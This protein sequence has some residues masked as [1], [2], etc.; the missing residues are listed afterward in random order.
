MVVFLILLHKID[1]STSSASGSV[2]WLAA[3]IINLAFTSGALSL[4]K[5]NYRESAMLGIYTTELGNKSKVGYSSQNK[6]GI[7]YQVMKR[8]WHISMGE[9]L[10][11]KLMKLTID[12]DTRSYLLRT[13]PKAQ[14]TRTSQSCTS[15]SVESI[16]SAP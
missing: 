6:I 5:T 16:T 10:L 2:G 13:P 1:G 14:G 4:H 3:S 7:F 8:F 12:K 15:N 11:R 9:K